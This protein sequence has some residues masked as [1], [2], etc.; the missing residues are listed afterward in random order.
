MFLQKSA[1]FAKIGVFRKNRLF[2]K[3]KSGNKI[4]ADM[5]LE[6]FFCQNPS[7]AEKSRKLRKS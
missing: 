5:I 6:L 3:R 4:F 1:F 7:E 2:V